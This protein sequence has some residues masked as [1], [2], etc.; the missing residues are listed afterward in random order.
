MNLNTIKKI[1]SGVA[2]GVLIGTGTASAATET[3]TAT[4]SPIEKAIENVKDSVDSLVNAKDESSK[5]E[6]SL[7][8]DTY[9]KVINLALTETKDLKVKLL[10]TDDVPKELSD[11]K[12]QSVKALTSAAKYYESQLSKL[13]DAEDSLALA[14]I[15]ELA[16]QF[17]KERDESYTEVTNGVRDF[18]IIDQQSSA[19]SV[20]QARLKKVT[21][22]VVK[23]Q[24][25]RAKN[26]ST[27]AGLLGKAGKL[28][29]KA[30]TGRASAM[31][32]FI[33]EHREK[34]APVVASSST[35]TAE[36]MSLTLPET[37]NAT[38]TT[39]SSTASST[40]TSTP[41]LPPSPRN[42]VKDSLSSIK[43][44]YQIFMDM[45]TLVRKTPASQ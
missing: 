28:I 4:S 16:T 5:D 44:A 23:L 36:I 12:D 19:V 21:D 39:A 22:D 18:L 40:G 6:L 20:A 9:R 3:S 27:L 34:S 37:T 24:K 10:A 30:S 1:I 26:A 33:T 8:I 15:R 29:E 2:L 45:S 42:L 11:W 32:A 35:S 31:K 41:Q 17:K 7:R 38:G 25:E 13:D 14:D 43:G